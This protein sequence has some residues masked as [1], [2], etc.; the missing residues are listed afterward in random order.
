MRHFFSIRDAQPKV[1][2]PRRAFLTGLIGLV[3]APAIIRIENLMPVKRF[4]AFLYK[5]IRPL[6]PGESAAFTVSLSG[7]E[8]FR[9]KDVRL[10]YEY[11]GFRFGIG[12]RHFP[13]LAK[14]R[15]PPGGVESVI[16]GLAGLGPPPEPIVPRLGET[17]AEY[18][19]RRAIRPGG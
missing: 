18:L 9:L 8:C 2:L 19:A 13:G 14:E 16:R 6:A 12:M 17:E 15:L 4:P 5:P 1:T 3:A 11:C 10:I 7:E